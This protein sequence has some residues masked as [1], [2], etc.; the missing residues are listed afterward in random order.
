MKKFQVVLFWVIGIT[1][2]IIGLLKDIDMDEMNKTVFNRAHYPKW[3]F[4]LV[5]ALEFVAG[6]LLLMTAATSK[7]IGSI[8]IGVVMLG[9]IGTHYAL[10]DSYKHYIVPGIIFVLAVLMSLDFEKKEKQGE[11]M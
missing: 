4:Y 11:N 6:L 2:I 3:F 8:L 1:F 7:R 5:G 10:N 9:A